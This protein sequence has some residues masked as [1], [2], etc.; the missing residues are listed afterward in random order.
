MGLPAGVQVD[1]IDLDRVL[2]RKWYLTKNGYVMANGK[3]V[4][5]VKAP[6]V[7][8]HRF[9]VGCV[10]GDGQHVDHI[11]HDGLDNRQGNLRVVTHAENMRNM[12]P[13]RDGRERG[14][15][16]LVAARRWRAHMMI[17]G[18]AWSK[19]FLTEA[20]AVDAVR[21]RRLELLGG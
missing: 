19:S 3:M 11:N 10:P 6:S 16:H 9:I 14:V 8:L 17:D 13:R 5:G 4:A 15:F 2:A 1:A 20:E 21:A 7:Y 12:R 18:K